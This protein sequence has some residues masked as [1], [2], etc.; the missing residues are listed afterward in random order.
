MTFD[1]E[2]QSDIASEFFEATTRKPLILKNDL[3]LRTTSRGKQQKEFPLHYAS[4]YADAEKHNF[5]QLRKL[6]TAAL[7]MCSLDV[8]E[9]VCIRYIA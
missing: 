2:E 4:L 5:L 7:I 8:E 9:L 6:M 1:S 3:I